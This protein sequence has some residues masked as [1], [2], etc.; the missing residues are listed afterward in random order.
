MSDSYDVVVVG[1]GVAG[2]SAALFAGRYG[3]KTSVIDHFGLGGQV[4]N[5]GV[6][7]SYPGLPDAVTGAEF[8]GRLSDQALD[9]GVEPEL[10][11]V[12]AIV[13]DG[14]GFR[15]QTE[16]RELP[17]RG[18]IMATGGK[19]V[20]LGLAGE[21][22][23][24][25]RGVSHCAVCDGAFFSGQDVMVVGG[26]E[27]AAESA[28][29]LS[30]MCRKVT[31]VHRREQFRASALLQTQMR[32]KSNIEILTGAQVDQLK[33]DDSLQ[34]AVLRT[35]E[36]AIIERELN[37]L[38]VCIGLTPDTELLRGVADLDEHGRALVGLDM[39]TSRPG[40]FAAGS[41]RAGSPDQAITAAADGVT[42]AL[43][44]FHMLSNKSTHV[45]GLAGS[46]IGSR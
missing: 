37:G 9:L 38:F 10:S 31:L 22:T 13:P 29:Y 30:S 26:G 23:L 5:A 45:S 17:A 14:A 36:G 32:S 28:V 6:L 41:I 40:L 1:A 8:V 18:V 11:R 24:E 12:T 46:R 27:A 15:V 33:G 20:R 19:P 4:L 7:D 34:G 39:Q 3:L 2:L 16:G 42:A 21:E 44:A 25:G 43:S 35:A